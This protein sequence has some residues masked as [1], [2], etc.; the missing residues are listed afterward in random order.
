MS[1]K[2]NLKVAVISVFYILTY[3][4]LFIGLVVLVYFIELGF[5]IPFMFIVMPFLFVLPY[6]RATLNTK[7]E[8]ALFVAL[9]L[10]A[11]FV[12][13]LIYAYLD[14]QKNFGFSMPG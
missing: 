5:L 2:L 7:T 1:K 8:K 13:L 14:F 3:W 10:A 11:P 9:G 12:L 6:K 4:I